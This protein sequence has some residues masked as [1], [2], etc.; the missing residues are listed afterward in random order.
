[1]PELVE[2]QVTEVAAP[3]EA[4]LNEVRKH[5][6]LPAD[7]SVLNFLAEH[8]SIPQIL[9]G[10]TQ[11]LEASFGTDAVFELRAPIDEAGSRTLYV[12]AMWPGRSQDVRNALA[13]FDNDWWMARAGQAAGYLT[14]SYELV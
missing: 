14:F 2:K 4:V 13:K 12:V 8:R 7:S 9:L 5:Y 10:A 1:M 6:V 11:Q 3:H